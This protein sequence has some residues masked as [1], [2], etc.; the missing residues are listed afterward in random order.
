MNLRV[1][2]EETREL[3]IDGHVC[4]VRLWV[5]SMLCCMF[6]QSNVLHARPLYFPSRAAFSHSHLRMQSRFEAK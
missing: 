6:K 4:E 5:P 2:T 3:G 1:E